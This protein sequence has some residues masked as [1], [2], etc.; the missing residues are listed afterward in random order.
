LNTNLWLPVIVALIQISDSYLRY[1]SFKSGMTEEEKAVFW[2]RIWAFGAFAAFICALIL[3]SGVSP[4][5]YKLILMVGW[6]PYLLIFM[7]SVKR[8]IWSLPKFSPAGLLGVI[9]RFCPL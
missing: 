2:R 7:V 4:F 8:D 9:S 1:L 5:A 6:I 3:N